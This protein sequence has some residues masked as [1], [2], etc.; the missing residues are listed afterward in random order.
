MTDQYYYPVPYQQQ[1]ESA[2]TSL[3]RL[4]TLGAVVGGAAAAAGGFRQV[5]NQQ[6]EAG[7]ALLHTGKMAAAT[8]VATA[9]AGAAAGALA[10][11]GL[12]RLGVMFTVGAAAMYGIHEWMEQDDVER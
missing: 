6:M 2:C 5:R 9:M 11:Q 8:G 3:L 10:D 1:P 4:A 7:Q 12:L